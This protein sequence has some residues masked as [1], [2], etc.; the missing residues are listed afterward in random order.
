MNHQQ[1]REWLPLLLYNELQE[2]EKNQLRE[3][4]KQCSSCADELK[5]IEKLHSIV[6]DQPFVKP[7]ET[8]VQEA[9]Q[10]LRVALRKQRSRKSWAEGILEGLQGWKLHLSLVSGA[11]AMLVCGVFVG[12]YAN[13]PALTNPEVAIRRVPDSP[14][15]HG[16]VE[17]TNIKFQD[18][19]P[20]NGEVEFT[21]DAVTPVHVKGSINDPDVQKVLTYA[22]V[23][24]QNPGIRLRA[25]SALATEQMNRPDPAVKVALITVLKNDENDGVRREALEA[26]QRFPADDD[27][28]DALLHVLVHDKVPGMRVAAIKSL[29]TEHLRD[30][31]VL[32]VLREKSKSDENDFIRLRA[33]TVLQ[34][35]SQ[36]Q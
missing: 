28:K 1:Y 23:N 21:L 17:L 30:Q 34:E 4:L 3:H 20:A 22:I 10:E 15:S 27:I 16:N 31:E 25:A 13:R 7:S 14:L 26:L 12:Y 11:M 36:K 19:D 32:N 35:V 33:R 9:R 8:L 18:A 6:G 29:N 5:Q 2:Q 24:E